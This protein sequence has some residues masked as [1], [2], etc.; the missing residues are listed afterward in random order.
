M[1][2]FLFL[3][4]FYVYI[5]YSSKSDRYYIGYTSDVQRRL[6][7][8]NDPKRK[9]KF[10]TKHIPWELRATFEISENR[11]DALLVERFIK[12]QKSR[13]F[14]KKLIEEKKNSAYYTSLITNVLK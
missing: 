6:E 14:L 1:S 8:H 10:T 4:V 7:E 3:A 9:N 11:G 12:K 5:L 2:P 13:I